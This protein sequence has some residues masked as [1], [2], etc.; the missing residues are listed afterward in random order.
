MVIV[1]PDERPRT[2]TLGIVI[3]EQSDVVMVATLVPDQPSAVETWFYRAGLKPVLTAR[4]VFEAPPGYTTTDSGG[5]DL[6]SGSIVFRS[7]GNFVLATPFQQVFALRLDEYGT[8]PRWL[9][10]V[11]RYLTGGAATS[12]TVGLAWAT[13]ESGFGAATPVKYEVAAEEGTLITY[14]SRALRLMSLTNGRFL[15]PPIDLTRLSPCSG[16]IA[17]VKMQPA[18]AVVA[19]L[20]GCTAIRSP[21]ITAAAVRDRAGDVGTYLGEGDALARKLPGE[22]SPPR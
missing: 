11:W 18:G 12:E 16:S 7:G 8:L 20:D 17:S 15:S 6:A 9:T 3:S 22:V 2:G 14:S 13:P 1:D 10:S 4:R 21:P 5:N 19:N